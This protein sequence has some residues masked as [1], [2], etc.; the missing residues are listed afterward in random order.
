MRKHNLKQ[1]VNYNFFMYVLSTLKPIGT[2]KKYIIL[3]YFGNEFNPKLIDVTFF[4]YLQ[5]INLF[6]FDLVNMFIHKHNSDIYLYCIE[7]RRRSLWNRFSK[8][9]EWRPR[10]S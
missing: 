4:F 9:V 8:Y 5:S 6:E 2:Y 7:N 10:C 3:L 1:Y